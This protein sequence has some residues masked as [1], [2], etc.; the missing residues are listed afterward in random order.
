[1]ESRHR[2]ISNSNLCLLPPAD[3]KVINMFHIDDMDDLIN[4]G[5]YR[6]KYNILAVV[7]LRSFV[8]DNIQKFTLFSL[9]F[10]WVLCFAQ[11]TLQARPV[12]SL[13]VKG[14]TF[15]PFQLEP[16]FQALV[17]DVLH[18]SRTAARG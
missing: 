15:D 10:V 8:L 16:A 6:L 13:N 11:F 17:M 7:L 3:E 18:R 2:D 1:V 5:A 4:G 14:T 12:K 9:N